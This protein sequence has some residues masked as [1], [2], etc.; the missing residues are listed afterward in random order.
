[1]DLTEPENRRSVS[2][3]TSRFQ[4]SDAPGPEIVRTLDGHRNP[5]RTPREDPDLSSEF[6]ANEYCCDCGD[7]HDE[8]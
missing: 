6:T 4:G 8:Y 2:Y 3:G 7:N 5:T 1:M